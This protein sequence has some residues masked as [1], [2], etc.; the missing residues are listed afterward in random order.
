M[1]QEHTLDDNDFQEPVHVDKKQ[2]L[3]QDASDS[4][5]DDEGIVPI[6]FVFGTVGQQWTAPD[7]KPEVW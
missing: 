4:E 2:R 7:S 6:A 1:S 5:T 3:E